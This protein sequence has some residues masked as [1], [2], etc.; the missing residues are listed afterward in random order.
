MEFPNDAQTLFCVYYHELDRP[1]RNRKGLTVYP[2]IVGALT[3]WDSFAEGPDG[4]VAAEVEWRRRDRDGFELAIKRVPPAVA[5][6]PWT[7][8]ADYDFA[9]S[10]LLFRTW[11]SP[12]PR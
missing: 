8:G 9:H 6:H 3:T 7:G 5:P 2:K 11:K 1:I 10:E 12:V 4:E